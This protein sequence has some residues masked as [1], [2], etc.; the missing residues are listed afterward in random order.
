MLQREKARVVPSMA[1][2]LIETPPLFQSLRRPRLLGV[3]GTRPSLCLWRGITVQYSEYEHKLWYKTAVVWIV[4][5][6]GKEYVVDCTFESW[7]SVGEGERKTWQHL[8]V[9]GAKG[10]ESQLGGQGGRTFELSLSPVAPTKEQ[11]T[12]KKKLQ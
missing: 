5:F 1:S 9:A 12:L 7:R 4:T 10:K 8:R 6:V 11:H 3:F 2:L